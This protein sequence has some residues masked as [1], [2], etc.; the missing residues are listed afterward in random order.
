MLLL[1]IKLQKYAY[2]YKLRYGN[3]LMTYC[4]KTVNHMNTHVHTYICPENHLE[5]C[6]LVFNTG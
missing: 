2:Q 6:G 4:Y 3:T 1:K 5:R